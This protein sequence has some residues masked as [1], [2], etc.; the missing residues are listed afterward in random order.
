MPP[1]AD[2]RRR[3]PESVS[4][5]TR[6]RALIDDWF[7]PVL[8]QGV[9]R[10]RRGLR[11]GQHLDAKVAAVVNYDNGYYVELGANDGRTQS[12]TYWLEK[13]RGWTGVL[14]EPAPHNF[15]KCRR[16]RSRRNAI[17][18]AACV[19]FEYADEFVR[20]AYSNLM[21]T[22]IG[23]ETDIGD[24]VEHANAGVRFLGADEE[25]F[26]FGA[27]ARTLNALL[28]DA[29]APAIIDLLS[30]DVE[31]AELEV[32]KGLNHS[33]FRFKHLVVECRDL[34]KLQTYLA[35]NGYDLVEALTEQDYLFRDREASRAG[36]N[37]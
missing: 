2:L 27:Q 33:Q 17:Y 15:L 4:V 6:L 35:A 31:G 14:V 22:P 7:P 32:L 37:T 30:L 13:N 26:V 34:A 28:V 20:I 25:V 18:C 24:P 10:L 16:N 12:N 5:R 8:V 21:S 29:G 3:R 36:A 9:V 11:A 23:L 1:P 19:S